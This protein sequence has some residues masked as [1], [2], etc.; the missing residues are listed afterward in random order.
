MN[1]KPKEYRSQII[2]IRSGI[3]EIQ[4]KYTMERIN[5]TWAIL[6]R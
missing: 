4:N 2:N 3:Y 1:N 5:K 6:K